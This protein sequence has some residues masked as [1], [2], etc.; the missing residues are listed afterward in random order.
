MAQPT[1]YRAP[2]LAG[3]PPF[4]TDEPDSIYAPQPE[5]TR[6]LRQEAPNPNERSSAYNM[7]VC[8]RTGPAVMEITLLQV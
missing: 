8:F 1:T 7:S 3:K 6:R 4:A 5:R 2:P